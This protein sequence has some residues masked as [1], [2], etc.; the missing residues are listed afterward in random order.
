MTPQPAIRQRA[1]SIVQRLI[2][3]RSVLFRAG[4]CSPQLVFSDGNFVSLT[5][6]G[7]L[8]DV[9]AL[10]RAGAEPAG[11]IACLRGKRGRPFF[12]PWEKGNQKA[13]AELCS[14]ANSLY[15]HRLITMEE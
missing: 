8:R 15:R 4:Y 13:A 14:L 12:K 11:F 5:Y 3:A 7:A 1:E 2:R 6:G 10:L 9:T